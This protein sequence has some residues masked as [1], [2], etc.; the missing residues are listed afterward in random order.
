MTEQIF[1]ITL[2]I[3]HPR[4][5][6]TLER[7]QKANLQIAEGK[8]QGGFGGKLRELAGSAKAALVLRVALY[9][10]G[11]EAPCARKHPP[12]AGLLT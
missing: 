1:P 4:W 5:Q 2:D 12:R 10:S 3:E 7:L 8:E 11:A 9:H 6:P